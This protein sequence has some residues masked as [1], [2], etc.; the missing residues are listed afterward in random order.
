MG[1]GTSAGAITWYDVDSGTEI[2]A[3]KAIA[4][5]FISP[6]HGVEDIEA[7]FEPKFGHQEL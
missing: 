5:Q 4:K 6:L 7:T 1:S 2:P 3:S